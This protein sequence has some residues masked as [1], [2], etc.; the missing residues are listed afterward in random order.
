M[1]KG[2]KQPIASANHLNI[3]GVV[4]FHV[5]H[6]WENRH[7]N[8][9]RSITAFGV[10]S[11]KKT[12]NVPVKRHYFKIRNKWAGIFPSEKLKAKFQVDQKLWAVREA[13][14]IFRTCMHVRMMQNDTAIKFLSYH[15]R[16]ELS[17]LSY[18][19]KVKCFRAVPSVSCY[20][21]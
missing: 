6:E 10:L 5:C 2:K 13:I 1:I 16:W 11:L 14:A 8:V 4:P 15:I 20:F 19:S 18:F 21:F 3:W 7:W 17:C 12:T 9:L